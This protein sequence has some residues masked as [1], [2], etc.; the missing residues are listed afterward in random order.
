M[1]KGQLKVLHPL[2]RSGEFAMNAVRHWAK[3][4]PKPSKATWP[5]ALYLGFLDPGGNM[6]ASLPINRSTRR[7]SPVR[8]P[9]GQRWR[10]RSLAN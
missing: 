8:A 2:E 7:I 4:L 3:S 1:R 5:C 10:I 6:A 9:R